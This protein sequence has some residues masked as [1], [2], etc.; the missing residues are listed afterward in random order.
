MKLVNSRGR[1]LLEVVSAH[2][3]G[4]DEHGFIATTYQYRGDGCGGNVDLVGLHRTINC[5]RLDCPSAKLV[6]LLPNPT[7]D[8]VPA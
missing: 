8:K 6:G 4:I 1:V 7:V 3:A 5:I 2:A